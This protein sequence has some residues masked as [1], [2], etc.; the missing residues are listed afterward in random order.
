MDNQIKI[1]LD[2]IVFRIQKFGGASTYWKE[3]LINFL[4]LDDVNVVLQS[5]DFDELNNDGKEIAGLLTDK[6]KLLIE[7]TLPVSLLRYLPF[8]KRLPAKSIY[9]NS[10][11]RTCFQKN[12]VNIFTVHDFTH[13]RGY[14][15]K[16]PR[17][18]IHIGLTAIGLKNADGIICISENTKKDLMHYYPGIPEKKIK[19]IYHGVSDEFYHLPIKKDGWF[20]DKF[21]LSDKYALFVGKRGGYK[22]FD[23]L[24]EAISSIK[25]LKLV[26]VGGGELSQTEYDELNKF[27][28]GRFYKLDGIDNGELNELYNNAYCLIY[29]SIYE[30]FGIPLLEAMKAGCPVITNKLSSLGEVAGDAALML[31]SITTESLAKKLIELEDG[32]LRAD[33]IEKGFNQ[34]EKFTWDKCFTETYSFYREIYNQKFN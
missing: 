19:V 30:G 11:Y 13:K 28:P 34:S 21:E 33:L 29:T 9:H 8:T 31:E 14:A 7:N 6:N 17:K 1:Y 15:S 32:V 20:R 12:V 26:M 27:L 4:K 23:I 5:A 24:P 16:F 22:K 10:Y 18:L 2:S 25:G 3:L